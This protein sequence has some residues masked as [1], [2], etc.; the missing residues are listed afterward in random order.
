MFDKSLQEKMTDP[1][2]ELK[3]KAEKELKAWEEEQMFDP[4]ES[5]RFKN[6]GNDLYRKGD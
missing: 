4:A 5:D 2:K 1:V 6:D 3:L